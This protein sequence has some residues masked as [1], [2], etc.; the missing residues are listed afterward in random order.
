MNPSAVRTYVTNPDTAPGMVIAG[1]DP[2]IA[3]AGLCVL[4]R[5]P[6]GYRKLHH[7]V[8]RTKSADRPAVRVATIWDALSD[9]FRRYHPSCLVIEDQRGVQAGK[10]RDGEFTVDN[11]KTVGVAYVAMACARFFRIDVVEVQP[12][13]A[14]I[15]VLG[16]G[17]GSADKR[18]VQAIVERLVGEKLPLDA[19]DAATMAIHGFQLH[20]SERRKR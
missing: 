9:A 2:S 8:I 16:K 18:Q 10:H 19:S 11:S 12:K 1:F 4:E 15:A 7:Q 20:H 3:S 5:R 6:N 13:T 17:S 14:K